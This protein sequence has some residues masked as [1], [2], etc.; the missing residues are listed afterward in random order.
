MVADLEAPREET[1]PARNA[2]TVEEA[3]QADPALE[4]GMGS[5]LV[6]VQRAGDNAP[7]PERW[8]TLIRPDAPYGIRYFPV[9]E[10]R[11]DATGAV[12]FESLEPAVYEIRPLLVPSRPRVEIRPGE[13]EEQTLT[14]PHGITVEGQVVD[15]GNNPVPGATIYMDTGWTSYERPVAIADGRGRFELTDITSGYRL[16]ALADGFGP[17]HHHPVQG[18]AG[19]RVTV[20]FVVNRVAA[21]L[22]GVVR[23]PDGNPIPRAFVAIQP[24]DLGESFR[25]DLGRFWR[26]PSIQVLRTDG[27]G[28][29]VCRQVPAEPILV[30]AGSADDM[31][32]VPTVEE[33]EL[34]AGS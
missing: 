29:F 25:D 6:R 20:T 28:N 8:I 11:T 23:G 32:F 16:G 22:R 33:L 17:S 10:G 30:V 9:R 31:G 15:V 3:G 18:E 13:R 12:L 21:T 14:V 26:P 27:Q 34:R 5:L 24:L 2:L 19:D 7:V 4:E 1:E